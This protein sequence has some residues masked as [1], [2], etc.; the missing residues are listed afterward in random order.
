[1]P[2]LRGEEVLKKVLD[3]DE[4]ARRLGEVAL[5]RIF[6]DLQERRCCSSTRCSTNAPRT[7]RS[8]SAIRNA[9]SAARSFRRNRSPRKAATRA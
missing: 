8:A 6:A 9:L 5:V 7:S 2:R 4:G 3:T 1:M